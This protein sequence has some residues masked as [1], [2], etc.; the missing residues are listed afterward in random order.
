M[1][2]RIQLI[3]NIKADRQIGAVAQHVIDC[4][5]IGVNISDLEVRCIS[6][7]TKNIEDCIA[8]FS[9]MPGHNP[10]Y[11]AYLFRYGRDFVA[12]CRH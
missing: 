6:R 11:P 3:F 1:G 5:A 9:R 10:G 8:W 4:N 2:A 7:E 12:I